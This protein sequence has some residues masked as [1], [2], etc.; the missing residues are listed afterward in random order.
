MR[1][2]WLSWYISG[3]LTLLFLLSSL[4]SY[5]PGAKLFGAVV[6]SI[7]CGGAVAGIALAS[8]LGRLP[9]DH[10]VHTSRPLWAGLVAVAVTLTLLMVLVG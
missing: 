10:W 8:R 7:A 9:R 6:Q 5:G 3:V 1:V 4:I 2:V